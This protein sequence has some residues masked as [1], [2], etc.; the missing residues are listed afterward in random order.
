M[1]KASCTTGLG[2]F[3]SSV[4][5]K[6]PVCEQNHSLELDSEIYDMLYNSTLVKHFTKV[7]KLGVGTEKGKRSLYT[8]DVGK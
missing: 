3:E 8:D 5:L 4:I 1:L 6:A 7:T 2:Y